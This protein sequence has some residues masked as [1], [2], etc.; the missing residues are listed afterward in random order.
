VAE[1]APE[2]ASLRDLA[3]LLDERR[4]RITLSPAFA[5][6]LR[7]AADEIDQLRELLRDVLVDNPDACDH[8][9]DCDCSAAKAIRLLGLDGSTPPEPKTE[10]PGSRFHTPRGH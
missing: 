8:P 6:S 10:V 4:Q 1:L 2:T 7:V 3:D 5:I 9:W